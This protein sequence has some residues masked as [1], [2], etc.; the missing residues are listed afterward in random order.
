MCENVIQARRDIPIH[1]VLCVD[2]SHV[3]HS[4]SFFDEELTIL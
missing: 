1:N 3:R 4:G 2:Y